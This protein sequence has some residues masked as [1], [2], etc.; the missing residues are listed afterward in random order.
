MRKT[1]TILVCLNLIILATGCRTETEEDRVKTVIT[2]IRK[3][4]EEKDTGDV[5]QHL[6]RTYRDPQ[7]H[8]YNG[9]KGL[10]LMYFYRHQRVAVYIPGIEVTVTDASARAG[11]EAVLTGAGTPESQPGILPET[12][13]VYSFDVALRKEGKDWKV[14]SAAWQRSGEAGR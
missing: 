3:A 8:D 13:G 2:K 4:A 12:L 1:L 5:L 9:I 6:S 10:L 11:F 7:D 14:V